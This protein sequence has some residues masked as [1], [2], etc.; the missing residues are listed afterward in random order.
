MSRV[1][2]FAATLALAAG[3]ELLGSHDGFE[4]TPPKVGGPTYTYSAFISPSWV[5]ALACPL[6]LIFLYYPCS[7]RARP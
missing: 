2:A 5:E 4:I 6:L 3:M 1:A 7:E